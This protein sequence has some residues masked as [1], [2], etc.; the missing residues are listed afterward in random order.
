[1]TNTETSTLNTGQNPYL[2]VTQEPQ[3]MFSNVS[4]LD[5]LEYLPY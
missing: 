5:K 2:F 1:M 4:R 3:G